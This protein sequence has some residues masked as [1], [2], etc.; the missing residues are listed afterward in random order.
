MNLLRIISINVIVF[1]SSLLMV[2]LLFGYWFDKN[3]LGAYMRE[4]R[5]KKNSLT[6]KFKDEKYNFVYKRNYYG[7]RGDDV[8]LEDIKMVLIGGSTADERYK[9]YEYTITGLINKKFEEEK[10][11]LKIVNAGIEGQS[12]KGHIFNF[13]SWFSKL[14][15]FSPEYFIFYIGINDHM[16]DPNKNDER[17]NDGH[18]SN[19]STLEFLK[20]NVKS[21]SFLYDHIRKIKHKYYLN[22][23]KTLSYDFDHGIKSYNKEKN[24]Y[25]LN[26]DDAIK[27][28]KTS[29]LIKKN[30]KL[31]SIYLNN[32]DKLVYLTKKY[33]AKP[34][35]INQL[36]HEGNSNSKLFILNYSLIKHC[37]EK[38]YFCIDLARSLKGERD[39]WWD[40]IHTTPTGSKEIVKIIYPKL[41]KIINKH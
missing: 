26:Y 5:M 35:F 3:N 30:K 16:K 28:Y 37:E 12:T 32:V 8:S 38:R 10:I 39:Y 34:I 19:P 25:F 40:G 4:H 23:K 7:F 18:V 11:N 41:K 15:K 17:S 13:E 27:I 33:N 36:T 2:E 1:F 6:V 20:D 24:Y 29:D 9:P 21:R 14:K 22:D 31:I